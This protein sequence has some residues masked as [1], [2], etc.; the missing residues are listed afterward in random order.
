LRNFVG[1]VRR[2]ELAPDLASRIFEARPGTTLGPLAV[3]EGYAVVRM[4]AVE[5]AVLD[6]AT[7]ALI[8]RRVFAD[9]LEKR[10]QSASVEWF[11]GNRARTAGGTPPAAAHAGW[12]M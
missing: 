8:E 9:W 5:R 6:E 2:D 10:R 11:W 4:L 12:S 3:A 7:T 1:Q